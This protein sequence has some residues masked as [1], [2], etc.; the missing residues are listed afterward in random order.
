MH[1]TLLNRFLNSCSD[2]RKSKIENLKWA[3]IVALGFAFAMCGAVATAQ[4]PAKIPRI[5]FLSVASPSSMS[6]RVEAFHQGLREL[7]YVE[8]KNIAI[9]YRYAE[10]KL[11]RLPALAAELVRLK[12]DAIVTAGPASTR[13]AKQATVAIPIVM[14]FDDDPIGSG[15]AASLAR[16]GRNI[17]GSSTL[18]PEIRG[19]QLELLREIVPK[20]S[21]VGVLGDVTR[22]GIPASVK[23]DQPRRRCVRGAGSIPGS[24][25]SQGY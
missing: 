6:A 24:T 18:S 22:P 7:G 25:W 19:K 13:A 17:T 11:D 8:G 4:Q 14:A 21:R 1:N 12:V 2:N 15:F 10:G 5:G 9:E 23:R 3:G 16:P 20:L